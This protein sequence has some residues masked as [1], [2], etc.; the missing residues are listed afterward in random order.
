MNRIVAE[1]GQSFEAIAGEALEHRLKCQQADDE[2][3]QA[4]D[5]IGNQR[6]SGIIELG[7]ASGRTSWILAGLLHPG[8]V[9]VGVDAYVV[10]GEQC[11]PIARRTYDA[12]GKAGFVAKLFE[13]RTADA[14]G[15]VAE[16]LKAGKHRIGF[17]HVDAGHTY[18]GVLADLKA[19]RPLVSNRG[20]IQFHD[21]ATRKARCEVWRAWPEIKRQ[22]PK[23]REFKTPLRPDMGIGLVWCS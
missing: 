12:L 17:M 11:R 8:G 22:F 9:I 21:I 6:F 4:F 1:R 15:P 19:Y 18:D 16:F 3:S 14:V 2:L 23:F 13:Q 10:W 5:C 20:M 7:V